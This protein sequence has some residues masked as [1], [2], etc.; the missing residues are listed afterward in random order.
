MSPT[1]ASTAFAIP[2]ISPAYGD[3]MYFSI[4][5]PI[6]SRRGIRSLGMNFLE[7]QMK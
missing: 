3:G 2:I 6:S 5:P 7:M 1:L 4:A